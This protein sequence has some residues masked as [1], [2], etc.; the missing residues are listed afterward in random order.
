MKVESRGAVQSYGEEIASFSSKTQII[1][2]TT[3]V[4]FDSHSL[5]K[6]KSAAGQSRPQNSR[7][8]TSANR[9]LKARTPSVRL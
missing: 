4:Y 9:S 1:D 8:L 6:R 3:D 7:D 5:P 2:E